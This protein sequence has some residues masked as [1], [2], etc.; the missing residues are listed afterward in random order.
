MTSV[1]QDETRAERKLR[2]ARERIRKNFPDER[3]PLHWK[4]DNDTRIS[5]TCGR[6]WIERRGEGDAARYTAMMKPYAVLG[7][8]LATAAQAKEVCNRHASPLPLELSQ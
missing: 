7:A 5:S 4:K 1:V 3:A 8:T 6:F 2:E